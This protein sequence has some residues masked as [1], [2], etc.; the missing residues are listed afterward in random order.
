MERQLGHPIERVHLRRGVLRKQQPGDPV[1]EP[2]A[3]PVRGWTTGLLKL[4]I[5]LLDTLVRAWWVWRRAA[6]DRLLIIERGWFDTVVDPRRYRLSP[7]L[8][9]LA[10]SLGRLV[11]KADI[12]AVLTGDPAEIH[13][14]K[15][16]L[17]VDELARQLEEWQKV[18][19]R[20]GHDVVVFDTVLHPVDATAAA[21]I[22]RI[23]ARRCWRMVPVSPRRLGLRATGS[24]PGLKMYRPQRRLARGGAALNPLLLRLRL[25]PRVSSPGIPPL[26]HLDQAVAHGRQVVAFQSST[27][28]RWIVG[29]S[30]RDELQIVVKVGLQDPALE[31]EL[32][33]L[34]R[35]RSTDLVTLPAV[36]WEERAESSLAIAMKAFRV[37]R[38]EPSL[39]RVAQLA[40]A[41][42]RGDL[43]EPV[44]HGDL[45][46]WNVAEDG[47]R[48]LVWDWEAVEFGQARP[49]D[50]LTHYLVRA[51]FLLGRYDPAECATIL[52][53][54]NGAGARH[55]ADLGLSGDD[56]ADLVLRSLSRTKPS[57]TAEHEFRSR[58]AERI[59]R[60]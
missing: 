23:R 54:Q 25:A 32:K 2:H 16:E 15:P 7:A 55:L 41:L 5:M 40:S 50:D 48:V 19:V 14:R 53:G 60:G 9:R 58:L 57:S 27:A 39:D 10:G 29:I 20:S 12:T 30:D 44:I 24:G 22:A 43:G 17:S 36:L 38:R 28:H 35:L 33:A 6:S 1:L 8:G 3:A 56:A 51:G 21:L 11:P 4:V 42:V 37:P 47:G 18:A 13:R 31:R 45:A 26:A 46:P 59:R 34:R 49:M 52:I